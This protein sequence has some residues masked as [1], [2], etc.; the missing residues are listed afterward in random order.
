MIKENGTYVLD[1]PPAGAKTWAFPT[2]LSHIVVINIIKKITKDLKLWRRL[3]LHTHTRTHAR[4][5]AR[6]HTHTH[7]RARTYAHAHTH[8]DTHTPA[9]THTHTICP[10]I[11]ARVCVCGG[12]GGACMRVGVCVGFVIVVLVVAADLHELFQLYSPVYLPTEL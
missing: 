10:Y 8:T 1:K 12:G 7:T 4:T 5:H 6:T 3:H 2:T 11:S 9:H